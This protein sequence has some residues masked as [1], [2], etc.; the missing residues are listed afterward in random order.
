MN[1]NGAFLQI[2]RSD[3]L[4]VKINFGQFR[5]CDFPVDPSVGIE[6]VIGMKH[7]RRFFVKGV[8]RCDD[9]FMNSLGTRFKNKRFFGKRLLHGPD[10][11]LVP[12]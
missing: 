11:F 12:E 5:D 10:F 7:G 2:Q 1:F 8:F 6:V 4:I 3:A 9:E